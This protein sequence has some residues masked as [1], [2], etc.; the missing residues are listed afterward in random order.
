LQ[1]FGD[2]LAVGAFAHDHRQM[3][4]VAARL[5]FVVV[6]EDVLADHGQRFGAALLG[7]HVGVVDGDQ[8]QG[9]VD[10][11]GELGGE[12]ALEDPAVTQGARQVQ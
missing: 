4:A 7:G 9:G 11:G 3:G 6:I 10:D 5:G 12:R 8:L 2:G 1:R